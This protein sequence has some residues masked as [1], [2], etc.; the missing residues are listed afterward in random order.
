VPNVAFSV[1]LNSNLLPIAR[2]MHRNSRVGDRR[3]GPGQSFEAF[4]SDLV[5][6]AIV[7]RRSPS[8]I[9]GFRAQREGKEILVF[10]SVA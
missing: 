2:E 5:T 8:P 7:E 3:R 10:H 9:V 6:V 1:K 4:L